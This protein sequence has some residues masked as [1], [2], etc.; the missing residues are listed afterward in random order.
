MSWTEAQ[1]T[2]LRA[3]V[4]ANQGLT[5]LAIAV[6]RPKNTTLAKLYR[7][8]L[9]RKRNTVVTL[10]KLNLPDLEAE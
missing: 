4:A 3:G 7:L 6:G 10:A 8:G 5:D 9:M 2:A 1:V